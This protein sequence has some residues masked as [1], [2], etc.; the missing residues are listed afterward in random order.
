VNEK[1]PSIMPSRLDNVYDVTLVR[2]DDLAVAKLEERAEGGSYLVGSVE[3][4]VT[5]LYMQR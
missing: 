5:K 3:P 4:P 2:D 1:E